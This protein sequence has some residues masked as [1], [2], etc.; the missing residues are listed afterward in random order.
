MQVL[1]STPIYIQPYIFIPI[2]W[3]AVLQKNFKE[4]LIKKQ[5][6]GSIFIDFIPQNVKGG[7]VVLH[8][9]G[10]LKKYDIPTVVQ[11]Y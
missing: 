6:P 3:V 4:G 11:D 5:Q 10:A 1:L 8:R 9:P 2:Y 7:G